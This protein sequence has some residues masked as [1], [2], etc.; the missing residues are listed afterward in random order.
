VYSAARETRLRPDAHDD[1][2]RAPCRTRVHCIASYC[3]ECGGAL[4]GLRTLG[5]II[6]LP[7]TRI[8]KLS[9]D[10]EHSSFSRVIPPGPGSQAPSRAGER[11]PCALC[12]DP[13]LS[14]ALLREKDRTFSLGRFQRFQH[15]MVSPKLPVLPTNPAGSLPSA[16]GPKQ[17][18]WAWTG[19]TNPAPRVGVSTSL[20]TFYC[21]LRWFGQFH[22]VQ[23]FMQPKDLVGFSTTRTQK[24][25]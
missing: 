7:W 5:T 4:V 14:A 22:F 24:E 10:K 3:I 21:K 25:A 11:R 18:G 19:G 20:Y 6:T 15:C 1:A 12:G 8:N 17:P 16:E 13:G 23:I 2:P 9:L